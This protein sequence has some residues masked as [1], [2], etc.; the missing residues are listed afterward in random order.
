MMRRPRS[1]RGAGLGRANIELAIHR[2]RI[3]VD[4]FA[5]ELLRQRQ[6][7]RRLPARCRSKNDHQQRFRRSGLALRA[8]VQR[9]LQ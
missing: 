6:R 7:Q 9:R 4:D 8:H 5:R 3:A 2:D 1:F